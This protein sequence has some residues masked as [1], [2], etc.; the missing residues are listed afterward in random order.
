MI[1]E[2]EVMALSTMDPKAVKFYLMVRL[3]ANDTGET[4]KKFEDLGMDEAEAIESFNGYVSSSEGLVVLANKIGTGVKRPV[5]ESMIVDVIV[6]MFNQT[7]PDSVGKVSRNKISNGGLRH[8][9]IIARF[10]DMKAFYSLDNRQA[11]V[12]FG[13]FF[14]YCWQSKFLRNET[15]W[16]KVTFD[17]IM[18]ASKFPLIC[19]GTYDDGKEKFNPKGK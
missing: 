2:K 3:N 10:K 9:T 5:T 19:E 1:S 14:S 15:N 16:D 4:G 8:K 13:E 6:K 7:A 18:K 12:A 17:W 11:A